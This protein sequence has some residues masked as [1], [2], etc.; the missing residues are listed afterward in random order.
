MEYVFHLL[1]SSNSSSEYLSFCF[2]DITSSSTGGKGGRVE[3]REVLQVC[4]TEAILLHYLTLETSVIPFWSSEGIHI[5]HTLYIFNISCWTQSSVCWFRLPTRQTKYLC[6]FN[7]KISPVNCVS[8]LYFRPVTGIYPYSQPASCS[9]RNLQIST[10]E[11]RPA[12]FPDACFSS[13]SYCT[14]QQ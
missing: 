4:C 1:L 6:E 7:C 2:L 12:V 5:S 13:L 9:T 10:A 8:T 11:T 14:S 3:A